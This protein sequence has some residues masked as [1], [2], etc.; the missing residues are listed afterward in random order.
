MAI[1]SDEHEDDDIAAVIFI[2]MIILF[3]IAGLYLLLFT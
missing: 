1:D 2:A 3:S